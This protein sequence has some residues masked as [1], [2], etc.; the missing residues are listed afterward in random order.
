MF[1][2]WP[3]LL[4]PKQTSPNRHIY[5]LAFFAMFC[6]VCISMGFGVGYGLRVRDFQG[7][8]DDGLENNLLIRTVILEAELI[9]IDPMASTLVMNWLIMNNTCLNPEQAC[10]FELPNRN[11]LWSGDD[12]NQMNEVPKVPIFIWN[13]EDSLNP[14]GSILIFRT[15]SMLFNLATGK[16]SSLQSYPFDIYGAFFLVHGND[17]SSNEPVN[18]EVA[19]SDGVAVGFQTTSD[20]SGFEDTGFYHFNQAY[21]T[22]YVMKTKSI[23]FVAR[24]KQNDYNATIRHYRT[25][26]I[27]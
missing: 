4:P 7:K 8:K 21:W 17:T 2:G 15:T 23:L 12:M 1:S 5:C 3:S 6:I 14:F 11:L 26:I 10:R 22:D 19:F 13:P 27:M 9:S 20:T 18:I 25:R 16:S 24:C